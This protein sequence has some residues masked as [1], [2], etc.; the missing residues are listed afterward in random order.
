[1]N[2]K[3]KLLIVDDE[4]SIGK[5]MK[6]FLEGHGFTVFLTTNGEHALDL[7]K[8]K[9]PDLMTLDLRMPGMNGF[10]V[11][12]KANRIDETMPVIIVTGADIS[13]KKEWLEEHGASAIFEKPLDPQLL[14][15]S[16]REF[17]AQKRSD[18]EI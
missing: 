13:N 4:Y 14:L 10:K 18:G 5:S 1:M 7:L 8:E 12:E 6:K 17:I 2:K 16:V 3:Y 9:H 15:E 11:L